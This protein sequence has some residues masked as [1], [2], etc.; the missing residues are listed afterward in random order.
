MP[1]EHEV[2]SVV[3]YQRQSLLD[4]QQSFEKIKMDAAVFLEQEQNLSTELDGLEKELSRLDFLPHSQNVSAIPDQKE[5]ASFETS[6]VKRYARLEAF[7]PENFTELLIKA[8]E[9][10]RKQ[11]I[12][13]QDDPLLQILETQEIT[14]ILQSERLKQVDLSWQTSDYVV[15]LVAGFMATFLDILLVKIPGDTAFLGKLQKGSPLTQWLKDHSQDFHDT[16]FKPLEKRAKVPYDTVTDRVLDQPVAG[17]NPHLHRL[18]SL[19]H[20]PILGF[21]IGL[22]DIAQGSA[23]FVDKHGN[24]ILAKNLVGTPEHNLFLAFLKV[25]LHLLSDVCTKAG[26]PAPFF[27]LLQLAKSK[28]PFVLGPSGETVS[29]TN[30]ARYMYRHGYDLRH[31]ATMGMI[32]ASVESIIRGYALFKNY[33]ENSE[34]MPKAKQTSM[35][36]LGHSIALSGN[37]LKTGMIYQMNPLALNWAILLRWIPL[38]ISW[39][40]ESIR[41]E[42]ALEKQLEI[43]WVNIYKQSVLIEHSL[44][45]SV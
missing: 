9:T 21:I 17:M 27:S 14:A 8:E 4:I 10:L 38:S 31:F 13:P 5:L 28:S 16:Y 33:E 15:V 12:D 32:P 41:Q 29:W 1:S 30:V 19:G 20:D 34:S 44:K 6:S 18:M 22:R 43:E 40:K 2:S 39:L 37:L 36:M 42:N 24:L 7:E 45:T 35:L 26:L 25:L 23:T 11:G 3:A